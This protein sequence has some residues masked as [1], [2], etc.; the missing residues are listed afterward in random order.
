MTEKRVYMYTVFERIWHWVQA[1]AILF[2]LLTGL[3]IHAPGSFPVF[4]YRDAVWIHIVLGFFLL[5]DGFMGLFYHLATGEIRQYLPEPTGFIPL[6]VKQATYYLKGIFRGEPH[7]LEKNP[8]NK[9]NPLQ[10]ITYLGILNV[11][12]PL[13]VITGLLIWG[14]K[15]FPALREAVG[16]LGILVPL[17]AL[18][19]W[20]FGAFIVMHVYLTTTGK[21]PLASIKAMIT[22][23]EEVEEHGAGR[24]EGESS[25]GVEA[26]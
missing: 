21:T 8:E 26:S 11:L 14:A 19:A 7:P 9:L 17:H 15:Q 1:L 18:V 25:K 3:E 20:I 16:G 12:L 23:W 4:G 10:K 22:G 5:A 13:Q 24:A 6:A 2:L